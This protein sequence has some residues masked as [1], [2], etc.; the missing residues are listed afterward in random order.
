MIRSDLKELSKIDVVI[1]C[2]GIGSRLRPVFQDRPKALAPIGGKVFLDILIQELIGWGFRRFILC[3]GYLNE[4]IVE[5]FKPR[6]EGEFVFSIEDTPLG[7]GGAVKNANEHI[8]SETILVM[9]GDSICK[10]NYHEFHSF[11]SSHHELLSIVLSPNKDRED[12]GNVRLD[13]S[14]KI[15]SFNEKNKDHSTQLINAG[16]Y[17]MQRSILSRMPTTDRFSLEYEF[18]PELI[19]KQHCY[20]FRVENEVLDIGTPERYKQFQYSI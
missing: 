1:L 11:H 17:L 7:T 10:V 16:I 3:V 12:G 15:L 8:G 14:G 13:K 2:G 4:K 19:S 9:N 6:N 5:Y 18:F 20:G